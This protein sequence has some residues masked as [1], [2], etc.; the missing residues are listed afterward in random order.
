VDLTWKNGWIT[1]AT[2]RSFAGG[3]CKVRS[4]DRMIDLTVPAGGEVTVPLA[5][6]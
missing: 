2:L 1:A 5:S 3:S 4:G 6:R